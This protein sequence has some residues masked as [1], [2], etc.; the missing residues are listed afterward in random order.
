MYIY[1][2]IYIFWTGVWHCGIWWCLAALSSRASEMLPTRRS[3]SKCRTLGLHRFDDAMADMLHPQTAIDCDRICVFDTP[4]G[5]FLLQFASCNRNFRSIIKKSAEQPRGSSAA[6][7]KNLLSSW[8]N[9]VCEE[10]ARKKVGMGFDK[11][12]EATLLQQRSA[13]LSSLQTGHKTVR[14]KDNESCQV[15]PF[16]VFPTD[17]NFDSSHKQNIPRWQIWIWVFHAPLFLGLC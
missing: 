1:I 14:A 8:W 11:A 6:P 13:K 5:Q 2:I 16:Q 15:P 7:H 17:I 4:C 12:T 9:Y 3:G 10:S